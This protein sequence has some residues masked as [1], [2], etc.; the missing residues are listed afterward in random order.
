MNEIVNHYPEVCAGCEQPFTAEQK[1]AGG[2]FGRHRIAE[3]PPAC[4]I[5][6]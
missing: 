4:V 6:E 3:L 1:R 2:R 5:S